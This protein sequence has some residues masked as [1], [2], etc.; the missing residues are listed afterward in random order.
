MPLDSLVARRRSVFSL[1]RHGSDAYCITVL[2]ARADCMHVVLLVVAILLGITF[3]ARAQQPDWVAE[4]QNSAVFGPVFS[5]SYESPAIQYQQPAVVTAQYSANILRQAAP[6]QEPVLPATQYSNSQPEAVPLPIPV[7]R[8]GP[9]FPYAE[10]LPITER[11]P[12]VQCALP[13]VSPAAAERCWDV[14]GLVRGYFRDDQRIQWTGMEESFGAEGVISPMFRRQLGNWETKVEGE[15][16]LNQPFDQN[17]LADT[18]ERRSYLANFRVD[19]F[20]ISKLLISCR[21][22]D[23][24]ITVGKMETPFGRYYF[25]LY[26][27]ARID[28]PYIRAESILWRETGI[29]VRYQPGIFVG[30][31]AITNGSEDL[32]SN[33]SKALISRLGLQNDYYALGISV[34][35]QDGIGSDEQKE[36]NNHVGADAMV[37]FGQFQL[38]GECIYDEYGFR[39]PGFDPDDITWYHSIYYRDVNN[40]LNVPCTGVGYYVDLGY[41]GDYWNI[42]L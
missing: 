25:P 22:D 26:S 38:S 19:T 37:R 18:P 10:A 29:L 8:E 23:F 4:G 32:D 5:G 31:V 11:M 33:S 3:G 42:D 21:R 39:R 36:F 28:A 12:E 17:I 15:F 20:E 9:M 2:S 6:V 27:N 1:K 30:D 14:G 40:A 7:P 13:A 41:K 16:Y 34:K 24:T 35:W